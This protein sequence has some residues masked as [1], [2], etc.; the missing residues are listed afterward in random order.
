MRIAFLVVLVN[1]V[2]LL[3]GCTPS[4]QVKTYPVK[5]KVTFEGKPMVGGGAISLVPLTDQP[6]KTAGGT[7]EAD[8]SYVLGTYQADD[9]SMAGE[10]RV[11]I[12]QET[13]K[14]G[15]AA[16]DGSAPAATAAIDVP[17]ADRI[18][19]VYADTAKSPLTAKIEAKPNVIEF[20]LKRQ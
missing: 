20:E 13:V 10:F 15:K 16:P 19:I 14:E 5:G 9:G 12:Y 1:F 4:G 18:P 2:L 7:I 8:G 11:V 3:G 17:V 6:G